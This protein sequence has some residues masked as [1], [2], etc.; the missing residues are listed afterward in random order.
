MGDLAVILIAA[1]YD[2]DVVLSMRSGALHEQAG[3]KNDKKASLHSS[4]LAPTA[5]CV[6]R[7]L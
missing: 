2:S 7:L 3:D 6:K 1:Q 5:L 4:S